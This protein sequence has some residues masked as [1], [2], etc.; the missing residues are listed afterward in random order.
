MRKITQGLLLL[1]ILFFI[2]QLFKKRSKM[3][4][5]G[6]NIIRIGY[7]TINRNLHDIKHYL[8]LKLEGIM[9]NN[10]ENVN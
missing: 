3:S 5:L 1:L 7:V 2:S 9:K 8:N 4:S 6:F 10:R